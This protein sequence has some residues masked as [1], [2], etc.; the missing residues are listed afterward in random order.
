VEHSLDLIHHLERLPNVAE[1]ME[2]VS[3][4]GKNLTR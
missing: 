1:V 4:K 3:F 2:I